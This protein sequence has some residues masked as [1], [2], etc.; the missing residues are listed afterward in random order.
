MSGNLVTG[1]LPILGRSLDNG[2]NVFDVMHHGTHEKQISN[3]F[4]WLLDAG[5]THKLGDRFLRI[6]FDEINATLDDHEPLADGTFTVRQEVNTALPSE[7][8]DIADVVLESNTSRIV[9]ENFFTSDGHGHGF[10]RYLSYSRA[11]GRSGV[12]VMLCRDEDRSRLSDGWERAVVLTYAIL[13]SRLQSSLQN[14]AEYQEENPDAFSF[15]A[16]MYQKFVSQEAVVGDRGV[17]DFVTAMCDAGEAK[18]Y[19]WQRQELVAEQF[20]SD[21]AVQARQRFVE[22]RELLQRIKDLLHAFGRGPLSSQLRET[23]GESQL[24][25][26]SANYAGI[27]RWSINFDALELISRSGSPGIQ[28][29]FGPSAWYAN[30]EHDVWKVRVDPE[31]ADYSHVFVTRADTLVITQ[32]SVTLQEVLDGLAPDDRRLHDEIIAL[33]ENRNSV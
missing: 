26:V 31:Y 4:A 2:F 8:M 9:I 1:L 24:D 20:A 13:I 14:D 21:I 16:Q 19:G 3:V 33:M 22:G 17:L 29:K 10:D 32:S 30:E 25:R 28:L 23:L 5:G 15:I 18:K 12:V 7:E 11:D 6:F 27:Y